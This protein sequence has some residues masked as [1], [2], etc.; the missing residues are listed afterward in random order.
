MRQRKVE[1][2]REYLAASDWY[3]AFCAELLERNASLDAEDKSG[4]RYEER[5]VT[6]SAAAAA[7]EN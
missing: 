6:E 5:G 3:Q 7:N 2:I 4:G 1:I